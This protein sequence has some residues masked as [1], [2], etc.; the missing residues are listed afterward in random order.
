M[1]NISLALL[2]LGL[3]FSVK[4][5]GQSTTFY[6]F[7]GNADDNYPMKVKGFNGFTYVL[8]SR[9]DATTEY[10]TFSK[11]SPGINGLGQLIW[12]YQLSF[13]SQLFDFEFSPTDQGF[14]LVG[15]TEPSL[16]G[17]VHQDNKSLLVKVQDNGTTAAL[18]FIRQY[19][20]TGRESFTRI[21]RHANAIPAGTPFQFYVVGRK[22]A[23]LPASS[24]DQVMLYNFDNA[25]NSRSGFP[26]EYNYQFELEGY[27]GLFPR[28][29]GNVVLLGDAAPTN[30][31]I[32]IEINGLNGSVASAY[33]Y[34]NANN[35]AQYDFHDGMELPN[36][37]FVIAGVDFSNS[38]A[39]LLKL[40]ASYAPFF[41]T[42]YTNISEFHEMGRYPNGTAND[43]NFLLY[44]VGPSKQ[45]LDV[46]I[47]SRFSVLAT[48][49]T[50][51]THVQ[52]FSHKEFETDFKNPHF[53][54]T[55]ATNRIFYADSRITPVPVTNG[56]DM[57]VGSFD[58]N[59]VNS[60]IVNKCRAAF[61]PAAVSF[62]PVR[63][64]I[65]VTDQALVSNFAP[66]TDLVNLN[67][68]CKDFCASNCAASF[69]V[70]L[71]PCLDV[72]LAGQGTSSG[73]G[74][75]IYSWSINPG[76][77][78][79]YFA[80]STNPNATYTFPTSGTDTICLTVSDASVNP[81]CMVLNCRTITIPPILPPTCVI[82]ANITANTDPGQ[83]FAALSPQVSATGC[84]PVSIAVLLTGATSGTFSGTNGPVALATNYNKGVTT[85]T[86]TL[87]DALNN[88]KTCSFTVTVVDKEP[89]KIICPQ[90]VN[91]PNVPLCNGGTTVTFPPPTVTDNC[92][93]VNFTCSHQS[94]SFFPCGQTIVTCT[95]TDMAQNTKTCTFTV[96][97]D[98]QCA[99]I[100][101]ATIICDPLVDD[102]YLFTIPVTSLSNGLSCTAN[103]AGTGQAGV[104]VVS[105][106]QITVNPSGVISGMIT[107]TGGIIPTTFNLIVTVQCLCPNGPVT[108]T[109]PVTLTP[110]CC[111]K[112]LLANKAVCAT[113]NQV[114]VS[115]I[116]C[117]QFLSLQQA[118]W[119]VA[120]G[121]TCP[122]FP[123]LTPPTGSGWVLQ[124]GAFDCSPLVLL[125]YLYTDNI[126]VKVVI[127]VG[128]YP[129]SMIP[130][131][132]VC[133]TLCQPAGCSIVAPYQEICYTG[134][135]VTA[136]QLM[137]TPTVL[138][139]TDCPVSITAWDADGTP[140]GQSGPT[141]TPTGLTLP[142]GFTPCFK[143]FTF[144]ATVTSK[145]GDQTCA[146]TVRLFN[147]AASIGTLAMNPNEPQ[148]F[149]PGEDATMEFIDNCASHPPLPAMWQWC[150]STTSASTGFTPLAGSGNM[151]PLWNTNQLFVD[152]WYKVKA[153]NGNCAQKEEVYFI[154]V[155]DPL[156]IGTFTATPVM[157]PP[158][159]AVTGLDL[160]VPFSPD[161]ADPLCPIKVTWIKNGQVLFSA[162]YTSSP[163]TW[164]Y[165]DPTLLGD[166]SGN[167][168]VTVERT[169]C[170][171]KLI[172]NLVTIDPP[173]FVILTGPCYLKQGGSATLTGQI[174]NPQPFVICNTQWFFIQSDG[175][176]AAI[177]TSNVN[178][179]TVTTDGLYVFKVFC[180]NGC[181][182]CDTFPLDLCYNDCT[183]DVTDPE[184]NGFSVSIFPNPNP[185]TF[186]VELPVAAKPGLSFRITGLAGQLLREQ[187]TQAG[188]ALQTVQVADLPSGLYFLQVVFAG[189]VLAVEKFV[190]D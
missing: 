9:K 117:G 92:P 181:I 60:G 80:S 145:C 51:F 142:A 171:G 185:G 21:I 94:G 90:N 179:I 48:G 7:Y 135:P 10:A 75:L 41:A 139:T 159:C 6:K 129:C 66:A 130:S 144:T 101:M 95:A 112:I 81:P 79:P 28:S 114:Q 131:N 61:T 161:P 45:A 187:P 160:A 14:L 40:D 22:N 85:V 174:I 134:S 1:K 121:P 3:L 96:N 18:G 88:M 105:N 143:D 138:G 163:A 172:S 176:L 32:L 107:V 53:S 49:G 56:W 154:D 118:N 24:T 113:D 87:T 180:D 55:P 25:G 86:V 17:G 170:P 164:F 13:P 104:T 44:T 54:I 158:D 178:T 12:Q 35:T 188:T 36:G 50:S 153:S 106:G 175:T 30:D 23:A 65:M 34:N 5:E 20:H 148:P 93:M 133:I 166:Y 103:V 47:V 124:Q 102:K 43:L 167:Y 183:N 140:T 152:H 147:D 127:T 150:V 116:G 169:C 173:C 39:M 109:F 91:V 69:Q 98:C 62:T 2:F 46:P 115:L 8:G 189:R 120:T 37:H 57:L 110:L 11:F 4:T 184:E 123:G 63:T 100:G 186:S 82:P 136:T 137:A 162:I 64:A 119:Y 67:M 33:K 84:L 74:P 16:L 168:W 15:H 29:T 156:S 77:G 108:C 58:L 70:T 83:C 72:Q 151:N 52:S 76:G 78:P 59:F 26:R 89:P 132:I 182:K 38:E 71:G 126:W 190:K 141:Y 99:T 73:I 31:G 68:I 111:R 122:P 128:D 146:A 157:T 149:C 27:L 19:A 177:G 97:I 165:T 125:P 42:R 155:R